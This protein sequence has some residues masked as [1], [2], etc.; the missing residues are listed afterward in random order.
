MWC[1]R[2]CVGVWMRVCVCVWVCVCVC[3]SLRTCARAPLGKSVFVSACE[4]FRCARRTSHTDVQ[5][6]GMPLP[7]THA[8]T[9]VPLV[10]LA[11]EP[12]RVAFAA[13]RHDGLD[14]LVA[15]GA[16]VPA[17]EAAAVDDV[18]LGRHA[19]YGA[20]SLAQMWAG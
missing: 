6:W 1:V 4:R 10:A 8:R 12:P 18:L 2:V 13:R 19:S 15:D 20:A 3:V 7:Q 11:A 9:A 14:G 16:A 17:R 5:M